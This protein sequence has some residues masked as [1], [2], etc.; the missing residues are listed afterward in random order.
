MNLDHLRTF[1]LIAASGG[2]SKA[3]DRLNLSQPAASRQILSLEAALGVQLFARIGRRLQLTSEG[4][5]LLVRCRRLLDDAESLRNR[6]RELNTG[7]AGL[8]RVG[9]A[10]Q[11]IESILADFVCQYRERYPKIDVQLIDDAAGNLPGRLERGELDLIEVPGVDARYPSQPLYPG[12]MLVVMRRTHRLAAR[13][14]MVEVTELAGEPLLL[15]RPT[16]TARAWIDAAFNVT[17]VEQ[18]II[19]ESTVPHTLIALAITGYG[20]AILPSNVIIPREYLRAVPLVL[21]G[22]PVGRWATISWHPDRFLPL[23]AKKFVQDL[24]PYALHRHP[25]RDLIRRVP[26]LA[27]P[28]AT[29]P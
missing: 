4:Q 29:A 25:G 21:R 23:Y 26:P 28:A 17:N 1:S 22:E 16:A 15:L 10:P 27:R 14:A 20:V 9:A 11:V 24:A 8:L 12:H 13:K 19:L 5:D 6:A 2:I 18:R 7:Q 3:A